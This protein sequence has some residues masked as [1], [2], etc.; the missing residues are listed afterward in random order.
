M[1][2]SAQCHHEKNF[3]TGHFLYDLHE[4]FTIDI[5]SYFVNSTRITLNNDKIK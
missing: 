1:C 3:Q 4:V 5:F 2:D